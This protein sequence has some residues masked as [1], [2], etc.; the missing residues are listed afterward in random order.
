VFEVS[1][2]AY[3]VIIRSGHL[4]LLVVVVITILMGAMAGIEQWGWTVESF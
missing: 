2:S 1:E 3:D 4:L